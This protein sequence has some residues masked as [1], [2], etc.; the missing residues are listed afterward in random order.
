[1]ESRSAG[2]RSAV[3]EWGIRYTPNNVFFAVLGSVDSP[4]DPVKAV[5]KLLARAVCLLRAPLAPETDVGD[6]NCAGTAAWE[7]GEADGTEEAKG[8]THISLS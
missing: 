2:L 8:P 6:T 7:G 1:M 5:P 3:S 4:C